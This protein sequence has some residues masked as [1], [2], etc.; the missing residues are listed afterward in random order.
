MREFRVLVVPY[1]LGRLREGVGCGPEVVLARGAV[2]ALA[3]A[4]ASVRVEVIEIDDR[5]GASGTDEVG[6]AFALVRLVADR[7]RCAREEDAFPVVLAGSCLTAVGVVAGLAEPAPGVVWFDAHA[8]FN[9][10]TTTLSGYLDGMGLAVLTGGAWQGMLAAVPSA[11]PVPE[12]RVVLAGA[13]NYDAPEEARLRT[14]EVVQV[15][16]ERLRSPEVLV[17]SIEA[18]A[19]EVSG[20]YLHVD[21]DV[22][23]SD[24][25]RVNVHSAPDGIS[26]DQLDDLVAALTAKFPVRAVSLTAYDPACDVDVHVPPIALQL[27]R[28]IARTLD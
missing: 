19:T 26:G 24:V 10:P 8:D 13:R 5:W 16:A 7:V 27:L 4:G 23:D 3:A 25:A 6:A 11:Q 18:R 2:D 15:P 12:S 22:L 20:L 17:K 28:T 9:D 1:E 21:L 14:S